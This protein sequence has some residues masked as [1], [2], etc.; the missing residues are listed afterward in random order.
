M[1]DFIIII[2]TIEATIVAMDNFPLFFKY[3]AIIFIAI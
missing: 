1:H 2:V 3:L